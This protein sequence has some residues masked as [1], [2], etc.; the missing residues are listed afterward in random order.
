MY[1]ILKGN[2]SG[3]F[4]RQW[5]Y[6]T[7]FIFHT[8]LSIALCFVF[9]L[10]LCVFR[11]CLTQSAS[12]LF[13]GMVSIT[14]IWIWTLFYVTRACAY[15]VPIPLIRSVPYRSVPI[16][17]FPLLKNHLNF[18]VVVAAAA[19]ATT[20]AQLLLLLLFGRAFVTNSRA[21]ICPLNFMHYEPE[22]NDE[23]FEQ[24]TP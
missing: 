17:F 8:I 2:F 15:A 13:F 12:Q 18:R 24:Y 1:R 23:W 22:R 14:F 16:L 9:S 10:S 20:T 4:V 21:F 19:A 3:L 7:R 11:F 5:F 6:W